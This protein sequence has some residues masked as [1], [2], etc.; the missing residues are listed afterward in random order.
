[1]GKKKNKTKNSTNDKEHYV[2]KILD[3]RL[4]PNGKVEYLVKWYK[5]DINTWDPIENCNNCTGMIQDFERLT[6]SSRKETRRNS[7]SNESLHSTTESQIVND[8]SRSRI[9]DLQMRKLLDR[10]FKLCEKNLEVLTFAE[11]KGFSDVY[12]QRK[13]E[14]ETLNS[15]FLDIADYETIKTFYDDTNDSRIRIDD[16]ELE[17]YSKL[18]S[19]EMLENSKQHSVKLPKIQFRELDT[20]NVSL[21]FAQLELQFQAFGIKDSSS[22]F[23]LLSGILKD[24]QALTISSITLN[25]A[26][27]ENPY[28][29]SFGESI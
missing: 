23:I 14:Y 25:S 6:R 19:K 11:S 9:L 4:D 21:W 22:K 8:N 16:F 1:M 3:K 7:T 20:D 15:K 10:L 24:D 12:R 28:E 29:D 2:E 27:Y 5:S 26:D 13:L 17:L 18:S